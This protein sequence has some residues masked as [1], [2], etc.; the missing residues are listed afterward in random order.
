MVLIEDNETLQAFLGEAREHIEGVEDDLL[1][2]EMAGSAVEPELVNK[3]FRSVHTV[4]GG[5]GFLGL[6]K[7]RIL[8]HA[9]ENVLGAVRNRELVPDSIVCTALLEAAD[10]LRTLLGAVLE[11]NAAEI[12]G[13]IAALE[14]L[15]GRSGVAPAKKPAQAEAG[16]G[17]EGE[18]PLRAVAHGVATSGPAAGDEFR[19]LY[20]DWSTHFRL[21]GDQVVAALPAGHDL[22]VLSFD[23]LKVATSLRQEP[24]KV[25]RDIAETGKVLDST[26]ATEGM[27]AVDAQEGGRSLP[28]KVLLATV[29]EEDLLLAATG[30]EANQVHCLFSS[31][32]VFDGQPGSEG[33]E[34]AL[35]VFDRHETSP[36]SGAEERAAPA[37]SLICREDGRTGAGTGMVEGSLRV[38]VRVLDTLMSLAGELVLTRNQLLQSAA[39]KNPQEIE[40]AVKRLNMVTSELQEAILATRMQPVG[41]VFGRFKRVVRD[42]AASLGKRVNLVIEGEEVELDKTIIEAIGDPL[43]HLVRNG[44]DH[45]IEEAGQRLAAGKPP[46][47]SLFL[48]AYHEEGQVVLAVEDDGRGVDPRAVRDKAARQ[49]LYSEAQ[50][51]AMSDKEL[52]KLIFLPGFSTAA[53]VTDLSGRGV[54]MDVVA[55]NFGRLGGIVNID[56]ERGRGTRVTIKLPLTLAIVP[57]LIVTA[58]AERYAIPQVNV[59]ELV[60]VPAEQV[61]ER[62]ETISGAPVMRRRGALLPLV[63]LRDVLEIGEK[64]LVNPLTGFLR[65]ERRSRVADR[66]GTARDELGRVLAAEGEPLAAEQRQLADRRL[67]PASACN[68][69]VLNAGELQYG[70]VVDQLLDAEEIVVKPLGSHLQK[71]EVYSGAAVQG[72]G[73]IALILDAA[74]IS[75]RGRLAGLPEQ[76]EARLAAEAA[77]QADRYKDMQTLLLV[78]NDPSEPLALPLALVLRVEKVAVSALRTTG[79]RLT[80]NYRGGSLPVFGL[81]EVAAVRARNPEASHCHVVIFSFAGREVGLAVDRIVDIVESAAVIDEVTLKQVGVLGSFVHAGETTLLVDLYGLVAALVPEWLERPPAAAAR[82]AGSPASASTGNVLV[83][84]D[85][86]FFLNQVSGFLEE[87]GFVAFRAE[88]GQQALDIL[89]Q[90]PIDLVLTDIEMP[91]ID[92][93]ELSRRIRADQRWRAL[94]VIALTSVAGEEA[95]RQGREAGIDA[96]LI[97]MDRE[98]IIATLR[99][100]L[101][102]S[103][104]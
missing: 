35:D 72:D 27:V 84:E 47:G 68:I 79:G 55:T 2:M 46:E 31:Q 65:E 40:A 74:G 49:G 67:S 9:M 38:S 85:S 78:A 98:Q 62:I 1:A 19:R 69:V 43:L 93:L 7:I 91:G 102:R 60:R 90:E 56:S 4:K 24:Q 23:L 86:R 66:R 71:C 28:V 70:L 42:L 94:P 77:G 81:E 8:S 82:E 95:E 104:S 73:R 52:V 33:R 75:V 3:L 59:A 22:Y 57:C 83:V 87:A 63:R 29:L 44:I 5:A 41:R 50:L 12:S 25:L 96:Y 97:K 10:M 103:G 15:R 48:M 88:G 89:E 34:A 6:E 64:P 30:L 16:Q 51:A 45:G 32:A 101:G 76:V 61:K 54:G 92:G 14:G 20:G 18:A 26:T 13:V 53:E 99:G 39:L 58:G 17:A 100:Y 11:S 36:Q 37:R 80:L 21:S